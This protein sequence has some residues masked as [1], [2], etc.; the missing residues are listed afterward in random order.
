MDSKPSLTNILSPQ[1]L[2]K[3]VFPAEQLDMLF[4]PFHQGF[5]MTQFLQVSQLIPG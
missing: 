3:L 4:I 5:Q 1:W 2:L